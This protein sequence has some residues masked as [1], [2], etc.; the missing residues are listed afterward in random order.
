MKI[1]NKINSYKTQKIFF[2]YPRKYEKEKPNKDTLIYAAKTAD[3][4]SKISTTTFTDQEGKF[5]IRK[6]ST[7][8]SIKLY[9]F[10]TEEEQVQS[11]TIKIEPGGHKF[12]MSDNSQPLELPGNITIESIEIEFIS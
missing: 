12:S 9:V 1:A 6:V 4:P 11:F 3:V 10:S 7:E 2:L 8:T 5:L